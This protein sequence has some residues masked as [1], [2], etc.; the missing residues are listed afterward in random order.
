MVFG[1]NCYVWIVELNW[2]EVCKGVVALFLNDDIVALFL[3][4]EC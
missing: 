2:V 4:E 1:F 3:G